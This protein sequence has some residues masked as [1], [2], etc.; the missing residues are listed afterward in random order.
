MKSFFLYILNVWILKQLDRNV[1]L[2]VFDLYVCVV[3]T[4]MAFYKMSE[5]LYFKMQI[6]I[7]SNSTC[8][9]QLLS[10]NKHMKN[11]ITSANSKLL[12][13][14]KSYIPPYWRVVSCEAIYTLKL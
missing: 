8:I 3:K 14:G 11:K 7:Q 10:A 13:L 6:K 12:D 1:N 9:I 5:G 4:R 2:L